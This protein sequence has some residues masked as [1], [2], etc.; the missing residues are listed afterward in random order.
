[1]QFGFSTI[2]LLANLLKTFRTAELEMILGIITYIYFY[3]SYL[4]ILY[5]NMTGYI[6]LIYRYLNEP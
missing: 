6:W 2:L 3:M 5:N 1:M 4:L